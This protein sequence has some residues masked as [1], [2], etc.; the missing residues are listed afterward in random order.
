MFQKIICNR[1]SAGKFNEDW[2]N[3]LE[4][5]RWNLLCLQ[6]VESKIIQIT[7]I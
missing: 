1:L 3:E 2:Q 7:L 4:V 6:G 5:K